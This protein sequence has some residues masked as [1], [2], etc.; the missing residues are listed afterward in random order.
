MAALGLFYYMWAFS[1]CGEQGPIPGCDARASH[2][3]GF[4]CAADSRRMGFSSCGARA[5]T[6]H[7]MCNLPGPGIE[8]TSLALLGTFLTTVPTREVL[9]YF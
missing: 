2:F 8:P 1:S 4:S 7:A 9:T 3:D 5:Q 6:L